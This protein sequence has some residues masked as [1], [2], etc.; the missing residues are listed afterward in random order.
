MERA[1]SLAEFAAEEKGAARSGPASWFDSIPEREEVLAQFRAGVTVAV[2]RR[3]LVTIHGDA[4][5][6]YA[7]LRTVI[8]DRA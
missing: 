5:T 2:I 6:G 8:Q 3:W 4:V 1:K 7:G